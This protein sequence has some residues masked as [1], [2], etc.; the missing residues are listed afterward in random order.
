MNWESIFECEGWTT[1]VTPV[2]H[3]ILSAR[4]HLNTSPL[5]FHCWKRHSGSDCLSRVVISLP[6]IGCHNMVGI[7]GKLR[8]Y[9]IHMWNFHWPSLNRSFPSLVLSVLTS[10]SHSVPYGPLFGISASSAPVRN[11]QHIWQWMALKV[12]QEILLPI[13]WCQKPIYN[14]ILTT[15]KGKVIP[16]TD[17]NT[18]VRCRGSHIF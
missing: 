11:F 3:I 2:Q 8:G 15:H 12:H 5:F 1:F 9:R 10:S 16:A 6:S 7:K 4:T 17:R 18:V 13:L 14:G